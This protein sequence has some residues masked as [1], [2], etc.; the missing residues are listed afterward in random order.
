MGGVIYKDTK[1]AHFGKKCKKT[2]WQSI[3]ISNELVKT[4]GKPRYK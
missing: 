4:G 3:I 1:K 2:N